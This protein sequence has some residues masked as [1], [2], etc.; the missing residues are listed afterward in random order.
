VV[1]EV[2]HPG[3]KT[4]SDVASRSLNSPHQRDSTFYIQLTDYFDIL[5]EM[6]KGSTRAKRQAAEEEIQRDAEFLNN[7]Q[8]DDIEEEEGPPTIDPYEVLGLEAE[9]TA[10][11]VKKAYRKL[12][13]K[14]HPGMHLYYSPRSS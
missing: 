7:E 10:D 8:E 2:R 5:P 11:D 12:A 4:K 3:A 14:H 13:L 9:A 1:R 6:A